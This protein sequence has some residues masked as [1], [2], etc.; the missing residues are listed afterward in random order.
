MA[1]IRMQWLLRCLARLTTLE[2][3]ASGPM[4]EMN[5]LLASCSSEQLERSCVKILFRNDDVFI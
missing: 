3:A 1:H 2:S 4:T 5:C